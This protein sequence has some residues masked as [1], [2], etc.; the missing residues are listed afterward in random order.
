MTPIQKT[1]IQKYMK[2]P[3]AKKHH[4]LFICHLPNKN[5]L[6]NIQLCFKCVSIQLCHCIKYR[7][8]QKRGQPD[9]MTLIK[10]LNT[11]LPLYK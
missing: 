9:P 8:G 7:A 6:R 1:N 11:S 5:T 3:A 2:L 4:L 10:R